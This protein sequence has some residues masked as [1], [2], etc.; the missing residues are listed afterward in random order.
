MGVTIVYSSSNV[1]ALS[2]CDKFEFG[3]MTNASSV[4]LYCQRECASFPAY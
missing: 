2:L 3:Q 4:A 1:S